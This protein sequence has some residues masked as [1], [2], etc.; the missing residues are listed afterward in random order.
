M[1]QKFMSATTTSNSLLQPKNTLKS[2]VKSP[3]TKSRLLSHDVPT[4]TQHLEPVV[5]QQME[6]EDP[7]DN[8]DEDSED[9]TNDDPIAEVA[10]EQPTQVEV[11]PKKQTKNHRKLAVESKEKK[12][13]RFIK[14]RS[15]ISLITPASVT[16]MK[17]RAGVARLDAEGKKYVRAVHHAMLRT[18]CETGI[19]FKRYRGKKTLEPADVQEACEILNMRLYAD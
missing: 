9:V 13:K 12:P 18:I 15:L 10:E 7:V 14:Q 3:L 8:N 17:Q 6:E 5:E 4:T 1:F 11:K 19:E 16:K 2:P